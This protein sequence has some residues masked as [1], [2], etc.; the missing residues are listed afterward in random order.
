MG[1]HMPGVKDEGPPNGFA[2]GPFVV[3]NDPN[4]STWIK[5]GDGDLYAAV[6]LWSLLDPDRGRALKRILDEQ[7][8]VEEDETGDQYRLI[9][10]PQVACL[11]ELL[12]GLDEAILT[13]TDS[14]YYVLPE[15]V[16]DLLRQRPRFPA[17]RNKDGELAYSLRGQWE[18]AYAAT[19]FLRIARDLNRDVAMD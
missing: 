14:N 12:D 1:L 18:R 13:F 16:P 4:D 5:N 2:D 9:R 3:T 6:G 15:R 8:R 10:V 19:R 17:T 11:A 7:V